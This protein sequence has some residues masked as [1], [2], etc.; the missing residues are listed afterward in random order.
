MK[1]FSAK[2]DLQNVN[3]GTDP[4][5][6]DI[7]GNVVDSNGIYACTDA[8]VGNIIFTTGMGQLDGSLNMCRYTITS[9]DTTNTTYAGLYCTIAWGE[10]DT[11]NIADPQLGY[12]A[13]IGAASPKGFSALT[14]FDSGVSITSIEESRNVD[15]FT[16]DLSGKLNGGSGGGSQPTY[17]SDTVI[18]S[19]ITKMQYDMNSKIIS[20]SELVFLNGIG[21]SNGD[22]FDYVVNNNQSIVLNSEIV[23]EVGDLISFRYCVASS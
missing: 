16:L 6:W 14:G 10:P 9:I 13:I 20:S 21:L 15:L 22:D 11:D 23:L 2:F 8:I 12:D 19:D 7:V 18:V 5:T 4:N 3:P 1:L 17:Q